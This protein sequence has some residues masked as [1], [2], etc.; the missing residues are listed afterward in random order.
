MK[1]FVELYINEG[2]I[3]TNQETKAEP[4]RNKY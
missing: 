2:L 3:R 4:K 1:K